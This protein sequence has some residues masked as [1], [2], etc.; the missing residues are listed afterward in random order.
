MT[1]E[2]A[3]SIRL[4]IEELAVSQGISWKRAKEEVFDSIKDIIRLSE[5]LR[6]EYLIHQAKTSEFVESYAISM[7]KFLEAGKWEEAAKQVMEFAVIMGISFE[8]AKRILQDWIETSREM[9][10]EQRAS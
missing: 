3:E 6:Q 4:A 7:E 8:D 1:T 9:I 5:Q 10:A 2:V